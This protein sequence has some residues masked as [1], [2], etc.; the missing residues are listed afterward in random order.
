MAV[1]QKIKFKRATRAHV[2][3]LLRLVEKYYRFDH[4]PFHRAKIRAGLKLL[5]SKNSF[6]RAW[7][8]DAEGQTAGYVVLTFGFDYEFGGR[9]ALITDLYL[10]P[11]FRGRGLGRR[12]LD[13]VEAFCRKAGIAAME[14]QVEHK[15][16]RAARLYRSFGFEPLPRIPMCRPLSQ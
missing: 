13:H 14:L 1:I 8:I 4:I 15:N 10:E 11:T 3:S 5:L 16:R 7:L 6:G 2:G 12:A 9:T